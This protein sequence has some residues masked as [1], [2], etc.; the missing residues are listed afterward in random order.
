VS[1]STTLNVNTLD[2]LVALARREPGKLSLAPMPGT[3]EVTF[4]QPR[5]QQLR[6][7]RRARIFQ[8]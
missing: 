3:T 5:W 2:E 6:P 8:L 4:D 7:K 1:V